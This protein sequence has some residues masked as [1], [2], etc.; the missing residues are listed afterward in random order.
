MVLLSRLCYETV[1]IALPVVVA[2][3]SEP[4]FE[5]FQYWQKLHATLG[6]PCSHSAL[7]QMA[8]HAGSLARCGRSLWKGCTSSMG[9]L[10]FSV[11]FPSERE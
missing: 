1:V 4:S 6:G 7:L 5:P 3:M 9:P 11:L 8:V 2:A 10:I